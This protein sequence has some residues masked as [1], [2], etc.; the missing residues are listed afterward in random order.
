MHRSHADA[1][2]LTERREIA[3]EE[4]HTL[5]TILGGLGFLGRELVR[6]LAERRYRLRI[7]VRHPTSPAICSRWADSEKS[8]RCEPMLLTTLGH[9]RRSHPLQGRELLSIEADPAEGPVRLL[10]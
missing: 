9:R 5:I 4:V 6:T 8:M 2:V 7:A 1:N 3:N 10:V